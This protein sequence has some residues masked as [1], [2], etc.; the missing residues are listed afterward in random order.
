[1]LT[2]KDW[3]V[4]NENFGGA[5]PIGLGQHSVIGGIQGGKTQKLE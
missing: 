5:I 4:L 1:M 2:F 3:K